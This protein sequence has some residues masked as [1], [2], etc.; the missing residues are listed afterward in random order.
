[1]QSVSQDAQTRFKEGEARPNSQK[2]PKIVICHVQKL[3]IILKQNK[4]NIVMFTSKVSFFCS[5][6]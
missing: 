1:M 5:K 4:S 2:Q 6:T 3:A